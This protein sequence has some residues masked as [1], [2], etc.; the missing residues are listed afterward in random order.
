M[1]V[2]LIL[3]AAL[4]ITV[5]APAADAVS[6]RIVKVSPFLVD[7]KG[8]IAMSPS[9]FDRDAYQAILRL[10][11]TNVSAVR[12]DV[13]WLA[14]KAPTEKIK[15]AVEVRGI[16]TNSVPKLQT[17]E[18]NVLPGTFRRWTDLPF[19]GQ[20][21]HDFGRVVAWRVTLWD[22]DRLLSEQ[23]SFLW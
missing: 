17:L 5:A 8:R 19:A 11:T 21:Y 4:S 18:T 3:L 9:H 10:Q 20:A 2:W 1:R 22:D 16:G 7:Q 15:I 12:F 23:K 14:S 13:L 6:G